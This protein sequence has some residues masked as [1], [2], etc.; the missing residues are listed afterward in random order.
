MELQREQHFIQL[1]K[2]HIFF[3]NPHLGGSSLVHF[4]SLHKVTKYADSCNVKLSQR[5]PYRIP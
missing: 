2:L 5:I 4:H 3:C 1:S